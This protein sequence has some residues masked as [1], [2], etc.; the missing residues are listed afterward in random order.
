[1]MLTYGAVSAIL[2]KRSRGLF[3]FG[4]SGFE[5]LPLSSSRRSRPSRYYPAR[6]AR[7][8]QGRAASARRSE[9]LRASTVLLLPRNS[10][11][12]ASAG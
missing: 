3:C 6:T 5:V 10:R 11:R 4:C 7:R 9:P 1:M 2:C 12:A 8:A